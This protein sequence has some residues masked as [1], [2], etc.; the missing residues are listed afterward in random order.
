MNRPAL[1]NIGTLGFLTYRMEGFPSHHPLD[2]AEIFI[3]GQLGLQPLRFSFIF[4]SQPVPSL[5][6]FLYPWIVYHKIH[7]VHSEEGLVTTTVK[8]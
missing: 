8:L 3:Y 4:V 6:T 7:K 1:M 2:L 5:C